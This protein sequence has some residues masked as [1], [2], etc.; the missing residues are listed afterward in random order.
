MK[1]T[2]FALIAFAVA[3]VGC[4]K[5]DVISVDRQAITFG[6]A[7]VDNATKADYSSGKALEQFKVWGT[8]TGNGNTLPLYGNDGATVT[9]QIGNDV[10]GCDKTEYW[11]P[12]C[13]YTFTAIADATDVTNMPSKVGYSVS[14][15]GDLLLATATA[16]TNTNGT[17]SDTF[18]N[19]NGV[20]EF[21]FT[22]LLSKVFFKFSYGVANNTRYAFDVKSISLSGLTAQGEY[23]IGS[24][25]WAAVS[26]TPST[27]SLSFAVPT[28][29]VSNDAT[30]N[31]ADSHQI[32][33]LKQTITATI[34]YD[35]IY[36]GMT[37][38]AG[39]TQSATLNDFKFEGNT[40]YCLNIAIPAPGKPIQFRAHSVGGFTEAPITN[41]Q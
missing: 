35:V 5:A 11:V 24:N 3:A 36:G 9:G 6:N 41:L 29:N 12:S 15:E 10:W 2:L 22:H 13:S 33:P 7:F 8:V 27:T 4:N 17:P 16:V 21:T 26:S 20:V 30:P 34:T 18:I 14:S 31:S 40:V 38:L 39:Q 1:K 23:T 37:I 25:N 28:T 32:L 19:T